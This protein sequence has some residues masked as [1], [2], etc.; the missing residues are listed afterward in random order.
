MFCS[1]QLALN[2]E[3]GFGFYDDEYKYIVFPISN[4]SHWTLAVLESFS[5]PNQRFF[6][7]DSIDDQESREMR[8]KIAEAQITVSF[9]IH[10]L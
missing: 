1:Q 3:T 7:F 10:I 4:G 8:L 9:F 2:S 5:T 6:L